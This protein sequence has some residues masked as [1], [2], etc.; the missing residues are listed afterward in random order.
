M[1]EFKAAEKLLILHKH[2][3][4]LLTRLYRTK[5]TFEQDR[6]QFLSEKG[7]DVHIK[8]IMKK[9]P[10]LDIPRSQTTPFYAKRE[11]LLDQFEEPYQNLVDVLELKDSLL[12][13]VTTMGTHALTLDIAVN[14]GLTHTF[15]ELVCGYVSLMLLLSR[16]EDRRLI[17][18]VYCTTYELV[19]GTSEPSFPR[20]G[21]MLVDY[22]APLKKLYEDFLPISKVLSDSLESLRAVFDRRYLPAE[23]LRKDSYLNLLQNP[24]KLALPSEHELRENERL[25]CEMLPLDSIVRWISLGYLLVPNDLARE[26]TCAMVAK[27]LGDGY[28]VTL[29]RAE[30][31]PIHAAYDQVLSALKDPKKLSKQKSLLVEQANGGSTAGVTFHHARRAFLRYTLRSMLL[32]LADKPGLLGPKAP[33]VLLA[34]GSV[35]DEVLWLFRHTINNPAKPKTKLAQEQLDDPNFA[36]LLYLMV[37]LQALLVQHKDLLKQYYRDF[38]STFDLSTIREGFAGL[39][40]TDRGNVLFTSLVTAME[41]VGKQGPDVPLAGMRMDW[42]RLQALMSVQNSPTPLQ[43][44]VRLA[45]RLNCMDF[46]AAVLSNLDD[47]L[48]QYGGL[49]D[50]WFAPYKRLYLDLFTTALQS[51]TQLRYLLAFAAICDSF[52]RCTNDYLPEERLEIGKDAPNLANHVMVKSSQRAG[53]LLRQIGLEHV[54]TASQLLPHNAVPLFVDKAKQGKAQGAA[55]KR[56][57]ERSKESLA[58]LRQQQQMFSDLCTALNKQSLTIFNILFCP[59]EYFAQ[60]VDE[61]F[62]STLAT[63]AALD[64]DRPQ[65]P[66]VFLASAKAFM[67]AL[68]GAENYIN[69]DVS[70]IFSAG[71]LE[72]TQIVEGKQTLASIYINFYVSYVTENVRTGAII[73]SPSRQSFVSRA[74]GKV[75]AEDYTDVTELRALA[76]ILGPHGFKL[77]HEE[78]LR[79]VGANLVE[80]KKISISNREPLEVLKGQTDKAAACADAAKRVRD[81]EEF[82]YRT[83]AIGGVLAFRRLLCGALSALLE[84]RIPFIFHAIRDLHAHTSG[85]QS[86]D[87]IAMTAGLRSDVDPLLF[88]ALQP[89]CSK[90]DADYNAFSLMMVMFGWA[91][92]HLSAVP[93][94]AFRATLDALENNGH[95]I[96]L[97]VSELSAACFTMTAT[98]SEPRAAVTEAQAEFLR[99]ASILLLRL[100]SGPERESAD[101]I[102]VVLESFVSDSAFLT[103]D[104]MESYF[105]YSLVRCAFGELYKRRTGKGRAA[106]QKEDSSF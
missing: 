81:G 2:T 102:Y 87:T 42:L 82:L 101:P 105:P 84:N 60:V 51:T 70:S 52:S 83:I 44:Q 37:E 68:R 80:M 58:A 93:N 35:R 9:F 17:A 57:A 64:A 106:G 6:P 88:R 30:V 22:D 50:I 48:Y 24:A 36:E 67:A 41:A 85:S 34:M 49:S 76:A 16:I 7:N 99:I 13:V 55:A 62:R 72:Q 45:E 38:L 53:E 96:A 56:S 8:N 15:L 92:R 39:N 100:Q 86:V 63:L 91:L 104:N 79:H 90:S 77:L 94:T 11:E 69:I 59:R 10:V 20:L 46:H 27:A 95:C 26:E 74:P 23:M 40:V 54:E 21:Q 4:G 19:K 5:Q 75:R 47:L 65:R 103:A 1:T 78:L 33:V 71:F 97:A 89:H 29:F 73:Y 61:C 43:L 31:L 28:V 32:L 3:Q 12:E 66:S 25:Y 18:V 98:Q 14:Y